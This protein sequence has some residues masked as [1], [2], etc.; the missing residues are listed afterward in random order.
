MG[1][2][3]AAPLRQ[4]AADLGGDSLK[5]AALIEAIEGKLCVL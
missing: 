4:G 1:D 3:K 2:E 5:A